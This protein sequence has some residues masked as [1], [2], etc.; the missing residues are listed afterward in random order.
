M[1]TTSNKIDYDPP[2]MANGSYFVVEVTDSGEPQK[3][4]TARVDVTFRNINDHTPE[5]TQVCM[6]NIRICNPC[7]SSNINYQPAHEIFGT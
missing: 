1:T 6:S 7:L 5:F 4:A 3:T 2:M